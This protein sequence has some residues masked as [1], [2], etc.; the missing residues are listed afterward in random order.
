MNCPP[1]LVRFWHAL[2]PWVLARLSQPSTYAGLIIKVCAIAGWVV[3]DNAVG[4]VAE[5]LAAVAGA[6]LVAWNQKGDRPC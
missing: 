6:A 2:K 1:R 5:L 3:T 4:Q